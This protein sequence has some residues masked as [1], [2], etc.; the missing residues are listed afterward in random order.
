MV[1]R[2]PVRDTQS[3]RAERAVPFWD[4]YQRI[5]LAHFCEVHGP[6]SI[7]C[8]QVLPISCLTCYPPQEAFHGGHLD[9]AP[10][11]WL[12]SRFSSL[13][14]YNKQ[15]PTS[16][17]TSRA[18]S[19]SRRGGLGTSPQRSALLNQ[20]VQ[21]QSRLHSQQSRHNSASSSSA[22]SP[23]D[24][25]PT[26]PR[27]PHPPSAETFLSDTDIGSCN[28]SKRYTGGTG[29][30]GAGGGPPASTDSCANCS[31]SLPKS[32]SEQLPEGAPGS[33]T[34]DGKGKNGSPVL[35]TREAFIAGEQWAQE[36]SDHVYTRRSRA[37][38]RKDSFR[39]LSR[40]SSS[41]SF[42]NGECS[43]DPSD[44]DNGL[45]SST[46]FDPTIPNP[47]LSQ[48]VT[49]TASAEQQ[50]QQ[51]PTGPHSHT[52]TYLTTRNPPSQT[53]YS[54]LR[55]SCIRTLSCEFLPRAGSGPL[56]FGDPQAGYTIAYVFRIRDPRAR[57]GR[58]GY[59]LI[60][61]AGRDERRMMRAAPLL[62]RWFESTASWIVSM[63]D[64][65]TNASNSPT[66]PASIISQSPTNTTTISHAN[67][68]TGNVNITPVTSFLSGR[69]HDPDGFLRRATDTRA[70]S[71]AELVG[72][73][74]FFVELHA[75]FVR[76]L[77]QLG[78]MLG[79][80]DTMAEPLDSGFRE[81]TREAR[82][83]KE[84]DTMSVKTVGLTITEKERAH[85]R[86]HRSR[87]ESMNVVGMSNVSVSAN[88]IPPHTIAPKT[89]NLIPDIHAPR[90]RHLD[91]RLR[92][93]SV[94]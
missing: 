80:L 79:G 42:G 8:T 4:E 18:P 13:D 73:E 60:C 87:R 65:E 19:F 27:S 23:R 36:D 31:L 35:R 38:T 58:R 61:L 46:E 81:E 49:S 5:S 69:S 37:K 11:P 29:H 12:D 34:K 63:A 20:H 48:T 88:I 40:P 72:R 53:A 89:A 10:P 28:I 2:W 32:V 26:S 78:R 15:R 71:L 16:A 9:G 17:P 67:A 76:L 54:L 47:G 51:T 83:E 6:T 68:G 74:N 43:P 77:G 91:T 14:P 75:V 55:R 30:H 33:P 7:L 86:Y 64:H 62:M 90:T 45:Q 1:C 52:L 92:Q 24:T 94:A 39:R 56:V 70:K 93:E 59:A 57:G 3:A 84:V 25:P 85:Q 82:L 41:K 66:S 50:H 22:S 44:D 21:Q